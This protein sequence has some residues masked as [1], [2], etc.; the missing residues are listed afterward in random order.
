[1]TE[2]QQ[3]LNSLGL[4]EYAEVFEV[5]KINFAALPHLTEDD[6]KEMGLPIGPR[7]IVLAAILSES[8]TIPETRTTET[9]SKAPPTSTNNITEPILISFP[10]RNALT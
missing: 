2:I 10:K 4:G 1:M 6:L 9:L 3:W 5:E 8:S 7:R